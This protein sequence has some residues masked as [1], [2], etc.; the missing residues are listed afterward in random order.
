MDRRLEL[1]P[2][3]PGLGTDPE[4]RGRKCPAARP[5]A[6]AAPPRAVDSLQ[7]LSFPSVCEVDRSPARPNRLLWICDDHLGDRRAARSSA[8][9]TS[10]TRRGARMLNDSPL[11]PP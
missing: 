7:I 6:V 11:A 8:R 5:T 10:H 4:A 9:L 2:R 1:G 3:G